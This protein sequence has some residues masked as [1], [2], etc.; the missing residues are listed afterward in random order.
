MSLIDLWTISLLLSALALLII[1]GLIVA[2][3]ITG[4]RQREVQAQRGK[5]LPLL[6]GSASDEELAELRRSGPDILGSLVTELIELVRGDERAQFVATAT[7]AGVTCTLRRQLASG[8]TQARAVAAEVLGNFPDELC[9]AALEEALDDRDS[10]VRLTS[11]LALASSDRSPPPQLLVQRLGLGIHEHSLLT[12]TLLSEISRQRPD[13]VRA[14]IDGDDVPAAVKA[15]AIE[16]LSSSG[17]YSLVGV[18]CRLTLAAGDLSPELPRYL[19]ALGAFQHPAALPAIRLHLAS[20]TWWVR[21]AAAE[22]AGRIGLAEANLELSQLLDDND[23][24]VR[25]RAG[26]ALTRLGEPGRT[27][28]A[29]ASRCGTERARDAARLTLAEQALTA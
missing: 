8:S 5:L 27:L 28:L 9:T 23:W 4:R 29:E 15:A 12:V 24:W 26:E 3:V 1:T 14:L 25:F 11:A 20:S 16:A 18:I 7:R 19:R 10:R 6:L 21:A 13:E 22:A 2:R 17:D